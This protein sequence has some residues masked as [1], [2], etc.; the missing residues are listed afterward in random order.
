[1]WGNA[2]LA[3]WPSI[4]QISI[5]DLNR[6]IAEKE[7]KAAALAASNL[8]P[9]AY[10]K[11]KPEHRALDQYNIAAGQALWVK[12][13]IDS[14]EANEEGEI[15]KLAFWKVG[16][17][18]AR[19][20]S[21][22][23]DGE[24]VRLFN[25]VGHQE[26]GMPVLP[27]DFTK[28][29]QQTNKLIFV[30]PSHWMY[31]SESPRKKTA[32][33]QPE[34]L[35]ASDLPCLTSY[36]HLEMEWVKEDD[37]S[38]DGGV[39]VQQVRPGPPMGPIPEYPGLPEEADNM[40]IDQLPPLPPSP[41][42][43]SPPPSFK[44]SLGLEDVEMPLIAE[45]S[46]TEPA[47]ALLTLSIN[48]HARVKEEPDVSTSSKSKGKNVAVL[49]EEGEREEDVIMGNDSENLQRVDQETIIDSQ[50]F[51][52]IAAEDLPPAV[53][54]TGE[55][56][57]NHLQEERIEEDEMHE[58]IEVEKEKA[59]MNVEEETYNVGND[60]EGHYDEEEDARMEEVEWSNKDEDTGMN[61]SRL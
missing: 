50:G 60:A 33:D 45:N 15:T 4:P 6:E 38:D 51:P 43:T 27:Y 47:R 3:A 7:T 46:T 13:P 24:S 19:G 26:W 10:P 41:A 22:E 61:M 58:G 35:S 16:K 23:Q 52:L 40:D 49:D 9:P 29:D 18:V 5:E 8:L 34:V 17:K 21:D 28:R 42:Q 20:S 55:A 39:P 2:E 32:L 37:S 1:M 59:T 25:W 31:P 11:K 48:N 44:A 36:G 30:K 54:Q 12:P 56:G 57:S 53:P 14:Q